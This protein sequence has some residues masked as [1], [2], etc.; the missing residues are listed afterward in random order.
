MRVLSKK[1]F[2]EYRA[3][4]DGLEEKSVRGFA[5][6]ARPL[7]VAFMNAPSEAER[8]IYRSAIVDEVYGRVDLVTA[9]AQACADD[10]YV[11]M[12]GED[13]APHDAMP[14]EKAEARVRSAAVHVFNDGNVDEFIRVIETFM[15]LE[16]RAAASSAMADN[17]ENTNKP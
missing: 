1:S 5:K 15:R 17:V 7:A 9:Q 10:M 8:S 12:I 13:S 4:L 6:K 3:I 16:V 11:A 2:D 14:Y